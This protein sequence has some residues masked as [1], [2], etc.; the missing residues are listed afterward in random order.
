M[1]KKSNAI[2]SKNKNDSSLVLE[3]ELI[4]E[5]PA[6]SEKPVP[7]LSHDKPSLAFT[8]GKMAGAV[9]LFLRGFLQ[10]WIFEDRLEGKGGQGRGRRMRV[11]K[12]IQRR[13]P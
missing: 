1:G 3:G 6:G 9:G 11:K 7:I 2:V 10:N 13:K 4:D 5:E 12:R 8:I